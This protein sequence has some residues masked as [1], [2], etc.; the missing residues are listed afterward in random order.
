MCKEL[1]QLGNTVDIAIGGKYN[2][3]IFDKKCISIPIIRVKG[4]RLLTY[5]INGFFKFIINYFKFKPDV[6]IFHLLTA[7]FAFPFIFI[8]HKRRALMIVDS[9]T[10]LGDSP[11]QKSTL[12]DVVFRIYTKL[13]LFC[14]KYS[15]DGMTVITSE[16]K[17]KINAGFKFDSFSIGVWS[18]G[19]NTFNFSPEKYRNTPRPSFLKGKFVLMQ[20]GKISYNRGIFETARALNIIE[21][22]DVCLL[23]IG[24]S[25]KSKAKE[26]LAKLSQDLQL[27]EQIFI[28]PSVPHSEIP[29]YISYCDCAIMAYPNIEYWNYNNPIKLL[30]Y[31]SM[32]KFVICTDMWTFRDALG[33]KKCVYYIQNNRPQNIADAINYSYNNRNLLQE[34]GKSGIEI[35]R[36]RFTWHKQAKNLINFIEQ[37]QKKIL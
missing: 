24:D 7:W 21:R 12:R 36:E 18:S 22:K 25:V 8:P 20:H 4:L 17:R 3:N 26:D 35:I 9:R 31:L 28:L 33:N 15:L 32:G 1:E 6:V 11:G 5:W 34:W 37:L 29:R 13:S 19:V 23:L 27:K 16:Y 10:P 30:E 2:K 14:Y